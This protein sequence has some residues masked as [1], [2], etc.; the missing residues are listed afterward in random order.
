METMSL[1]E[2]YT[3]DEMERILQRALAQ[4]SQSGNVSREQLVEVGKEIGL[5]EQDLMRAIDDEMRYGPF[6]EAKREVI[7]KKRCQWRRHFLSYLGVNAS[8]LVL[9]A[10]QMHGRLTWALAPLFSW[11]IGMTVHTVSTFFPTKKELNKAAKKL[12]RKRDKYN[13]LGE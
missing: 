10:I 9:N 8:L 4:R 3:Q 1:P 13:E 5:T 11:G 12:L 2:K 7:K 6:D